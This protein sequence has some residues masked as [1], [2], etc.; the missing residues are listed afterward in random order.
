MANIQHPI[1][2]PPVF[3]EE[4]HQ[5]IIQLTTGWLLREIQ[6]FNKRVHTPSSGWGHYLLTYKV[7]RHKADRRQSPGWVENCKQSLEDPLIINKLHM[8][9]TE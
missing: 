5:P 1:I 8:I 3:G 6:H 2:R 4:I 7:I 9:F